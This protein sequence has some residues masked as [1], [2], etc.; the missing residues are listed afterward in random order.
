ML[1]HSCCANRRSCVLRTEAS[2]FDPVWLSQRITSPLS[3]DVWN[4]LESLKFFL[5]SLEEFKEIILFEV[6][7][8]YAVLDITLQG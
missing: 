8:D 2:N 4:C 7:V 3:Y 6:F 5:F 1:E